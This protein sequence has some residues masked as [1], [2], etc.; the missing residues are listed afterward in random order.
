MELAGL[1][2]ATS[3][4]RCIAGAKWWAP[5]GRESASI[6]GRF[7]FGADRRERVLRVRMYPFGTRAASPASKAANA[8][9]LSPRLDST[10]SEDLLFFRV[11][12]ATW[13]ASSPDPVTAWM[14]V[15]GSG[16]LPRKAT[17][18]SPILPANRHQRRLPRSRTRPSTPLSEKPTVHAQSPPATG[19]ALR[20][21]PAADSP[22]ASPETARRSSSAPP[23]GYTQIRARPRAAFD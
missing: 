16:L 8:L 13:T 15:A 6:Y 21:T 20:P 19:N 11:T 10:R 22:T 4:V 12:P 7:G 1:E 5:L 14:A 3:W 23:H 2:P 18:E 17:L 9:I